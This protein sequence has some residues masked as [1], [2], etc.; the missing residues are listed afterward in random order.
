MGLATGIDYSLFIVSRYREERLA[1][2]DK[3]DALTV[4][5]GTASRAVFFSG[6]TVVLALLGMLIVPT[7]IFASLAIG[8]ILV[9]TMAV[10]AALTLLPAVLS[11]LGDKID[12]LR[13]PAIWGGG[14]STA[15]A[16]GR[17]SLIAR[18]A[19]RAMRRPAIALAIRAGVLLLAAAPSLGH[20]D[21]RLG[22]ATLP[23]DFESKKGFA[24]LDEQ[25]SA[26]AR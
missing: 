13:V 6:M 24:V 21:R 22:V 17:V 3:V 25:F 7:N 1:G 23:D 18:L 19:Q 2:R 5:G 20:E 26:G 10:A 11:L 16:D 9:V 14:C 15:R 8:A 4:T 12:R